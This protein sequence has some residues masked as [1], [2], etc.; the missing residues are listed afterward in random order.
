M[1]RLSKY[2]KG[3]ALC[4]TGVRSNRRL[5]EPMINDFIEYWSATRLLLAGGNPYSPAELLRAQQ[6]AGWQQTEPLFM[7]NPPWTFSFILPIGWLDYASAQFLWFLLHALIVFIGAR[8]LWRIYGGESRRSRYAW[9]SVLSFAPV[10]FVLLLGQIGPV[11]LLGLIGFLHFAQRKAWTLAGA[12]LSLV[13]IK[14]HLLYLLW[15]AWI[16]W[17]VKERDW[18]AGAGALVAGALAA[19]MPLGWNTAVYGQYLQLIH[20]SE[21]LRPFD[22]ATPSLGTAIA[23]WF[24][25]RGAW[26][27]WLPSGAGIVWFLWYW[28]RR[29]ES[30][31]WIAEL[32]LVL[33]ASVVTASFAWTFDYVV[34]VPA[35]VQGAVW[36][37]AADRGWQRRI[38]AIHVF[39]TLAAVGS[40]ILVRNDFWYFWLAPAYLCFYC[41]LRYSR[42]GPHARSE[43]G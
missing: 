40:K 2:H 25:V 22:W 32:P 21:A 11:I 31:D 23:A 26:I 1:D 36:T 6:A 16:L 20:N 13:A 9:I 12:S 37:S 38:A 39:I 19:A 10:H 43:R 42:L 29:R 3:S 5:H 4:Y 15:L 28:S 14:P 8:A 24:A 7:W 34:L 17:V 33:L 41:Y 18:R 27:R 35:L 30:W